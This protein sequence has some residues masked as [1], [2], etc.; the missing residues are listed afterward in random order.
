MTIMGA[1]KKLAIY[2]PIANMASGGLGYLYN[3]WGWI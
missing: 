3:A 1:A 2:T